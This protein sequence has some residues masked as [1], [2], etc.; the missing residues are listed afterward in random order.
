M[1]AARVLP[2]D[3]A[4]ALHKRL[5]R[6]EHRLYPDAVAALAEGRLVVNGTHVEWKGQ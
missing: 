3:D 5:Q 2:E 6:V 4:A 1:G